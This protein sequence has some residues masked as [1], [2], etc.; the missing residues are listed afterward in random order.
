ME[1]MIESSGKLFMMNYKTY[2]RKVML[3]LYKQVK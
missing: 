3:M 1:G 2:V